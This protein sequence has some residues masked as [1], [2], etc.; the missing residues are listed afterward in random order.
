MP[1]NLLINLLLEN[2]PFLSDAITCKNLIAHIFKISK[3]LIV[4]TLIKP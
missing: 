3:A 4:L 1:I 2:N